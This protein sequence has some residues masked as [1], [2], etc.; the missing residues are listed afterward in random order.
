M[1]NTLNR[2]NH[3][4]K[5]ES[6]FSLLELL[7]AVAILAVGLI[8][9]QSLE[10]QNIDA[11]NYINDLSIAMMLADYRLGEE[12]IKA[13][14]GD[15]TPPPLKSFTAQFPSFT[16]DTTL[17]NGLSLPIELPINLPDVL[18]VNVIWKFHSNKESLMII[19]YLPAALSM[20]QGTA[21][22]PLKP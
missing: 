3:K 18:A 15:L 5:R 22:T 8:S 14:F 19:D 6:G 21:N 12:Q 16:V 1:T 11:S 10:N 4:K 17:E 7:V 2:K 9:I 13:N 20:T